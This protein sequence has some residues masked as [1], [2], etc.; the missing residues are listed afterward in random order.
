MRF[1][2]RHAKQILL[3]NFSRTLNDVLTLYLWTGTR[4]SEIV[5]MEKSEFRDEEDG[6]WWTVP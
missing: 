4:G 6:F 5:S 2:A 1:D 3:P